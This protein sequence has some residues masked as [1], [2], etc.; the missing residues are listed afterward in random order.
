[1]SDDRIAALVSAHT[2]EAEQTKDD[3]YPSGV[4]VQRR[5]ARNAPISVRLSDGERA[6]LENAAAARGIGVSTYARELITRALAADGHALGG[7]GMI[8]VEQIRHI[9]DEAIAPLRTEIARLH[10]AA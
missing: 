4:E 3:P 1:M 2:A 9:V 5:A 10:D 6:A 8:P 7:D